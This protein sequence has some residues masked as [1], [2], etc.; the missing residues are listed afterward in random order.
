MLSIML[1]SIA[2]LF[3]RFFNS[4]P[5]V[6]VFNF[7]FHQN[8][9]LYKYFLSFDEIIQSKVV[10]WLYMNSNLLAAIFINKYYMLFKFK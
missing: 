9:S 10:P 1:E 6:F 2:I 8:K 4:L 5:T 3:P 7:S